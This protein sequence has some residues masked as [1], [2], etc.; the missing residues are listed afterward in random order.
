MQLLN[1]VQKTKPPKARAI[2]T[3]KIRGRHREGHLW[4]IKLS[5]LS[6]GESGTWPSWAGEGGYG[7][8]EQGEGALVGGYGARLVEKGQFSPA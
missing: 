6:I 4:D 3:R 7:A 8:Y 2:E 1:T 5:S